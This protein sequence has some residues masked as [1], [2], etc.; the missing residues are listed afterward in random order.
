MPASRV[1][2]PT[3]RSPIRSV[4]FSPGSRRLPA[5]HHGVG[6]GIRGRAAAEQN[7]RFGP[8]VPQLVGRPRWD[9]DA[10]ARRHLGLVAVQAQ[11][12][13]PC[14]EVVELLAARVVVLGRLLAGLHRCLG[15]ALVLSRGPRR[16]SQLTDRRAVG[17][18]EG[19]AFCEV[20]FLHGSAAPHFTFSN[21]PVS[22]SLATWWSISC[23]LVSGSARRISI[24]RRPLNLKISST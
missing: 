23:S 15:Q 9:D 2:T 14:D 16:M 11:A 1:S 3:T 21:S 13:L 17:G 4:L 18:D 20:G 10:I 22:M 24:V 6:V 5:G 12:P 8:G 19:L 7:E